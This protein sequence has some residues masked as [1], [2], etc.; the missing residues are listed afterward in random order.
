MTKKQ[1][2]HNFLVQPAQCD[3]WGVYNHHIKTQ[4][5]V[6]FWPVTQARQS[7]CNFI[8]DLIVQLQRINL[9]VYTVR[10]LYNDFLYKQHFT[11]MTVFFVIYVICSSQQHSLQQQ[12]IYRQTVLLY[13]LQCFRLFGFCLLLL[14]VIWYAG[15]EIMSRNHTKHLMIDPL[16]SFL[17]F[18]TTLW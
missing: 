4:K 2:Q 16:A 15:W 14:Q 8:S 18:Y 6:F 17:L 1:E 7:N 9:A 3:S 5:H 10:S 13:I 12:K 11:I